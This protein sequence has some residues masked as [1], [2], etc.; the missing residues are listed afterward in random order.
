MAA[1]RFPWRM[2]YPRGRT[3]MREHRCVSNHAPTR[4]RKF[5]FWLPAI[6]LFA[7]LATLSTLWP[8]VARAQ[9][10]ADS[11]IV[12]QWTAPGDDGI[13]GRASSY[14]LRYR[15]VNVTGTD[16][17]SW[18][19]SATQAAGEPAPGVAGVTDSLRIR[20]LQPLTTYYVIVRAA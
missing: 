6:G 9:T 4:S 15:T 7:G 5:S 12:L 10:S 16:T 13:V 8:A 3:S 19:N 14:D 18:W 20:G 1:R 2:R 11:S 17:L